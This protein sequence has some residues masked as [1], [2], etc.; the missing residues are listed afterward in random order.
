MYRISTVMKFSYP[1]WIKVSSYNLFF[2]NCYCDCF[3]FFLFYWYY[4]KNIYEFSASSFLLDISQLNYLHLT[5]AVYLPPLPIN[6]EFPCQRQHASFLSPVGTL[7][8]HKGFKISHHLAHIKVASYQKIDG[9]NSTKP[10]LPLRECGASK[11]NGNGASLCKTPQKR[12]RQ[13][14]GGDGGFTNRCVIT[15][16]S[17]GSTSLPLLL[18]D[19]L[20]KKRRS[21]LIRFDAFDVSHRFYHYNVS[22]FVSVA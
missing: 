21:H 3:L 17:R 15:T 7:L 1:K 4:L 8:S 2:V 11:R 13:F 6:T 16:S 19:R 22:V 5:F 18:Q 9:T 14:G 20:K 12:L 10:P